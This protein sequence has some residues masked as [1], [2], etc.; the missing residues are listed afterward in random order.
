[1]Q[2]STRKQHS[3]QRKQG[4]LRPGWLPQRWAGFGW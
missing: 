2:Q 1:L 3:L 4:Q